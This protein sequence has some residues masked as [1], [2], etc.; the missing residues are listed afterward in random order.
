MPIVWHPYRWWDWRLSEDEKK[1]ID[2]IF[3]EE[4]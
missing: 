2:S 4:L 3:N 1:E